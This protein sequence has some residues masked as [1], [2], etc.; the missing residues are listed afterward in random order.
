[1]HYCTSFTA[2]EGRERAVTRKSIT[3]QSLS[4]MHHL[5]A[6]HI[7][8]LYHAHH[9]PVCGQVQNHTCHL[10][11]MH[12]GLWSSIAFQ[13]SSLPCT[14][15]FNAKQSSVLNCFRW[16]KMFDLIIG[17][18]NAHYSDMWLCRYIYV[19]MNKC[20]AMWVKQSVEGLQIYMRLDWCKWGRHYATGLMPPLTA[21]HCTVLMHWNPFSVVHYVSGLM[22]PLTT[23]HCTYICTAKC[24]KSIK[25]RQQSHW[26]SETLTFH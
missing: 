11:V 21:V 17:S 12:C 2:G 4:Y 14:G 7:Y 19:Q 26:L 18:V 23:L 13:N 15:E 16:I 25:F 5:Y 8:I 9:T 22:A 10:C 6:Q 1:M 3:I 24:S 20:A